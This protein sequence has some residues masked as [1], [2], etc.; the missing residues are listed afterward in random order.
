[1]N[2]YAF[3]QTAASHFESNTQRPQSTQ[4]HVHNDNIHNNRPRAPMAFLR[5]RTA[6]KVSSSSF[7]SV[8]TAG[9]SKHETNSC[10]LRYRKAVAST[11]L[12]LI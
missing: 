4:C 7:I 12:Y 6:H 1:L 3:R 8:K 2:L 5:N 10:K 9:M 11:H